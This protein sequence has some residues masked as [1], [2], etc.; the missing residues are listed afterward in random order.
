MIISNIRRKDKL[1]ID[2]DVNAWEKFIKE[3]KFINS[4][5]SYFTSEF[6]EKYLFGFNQYINGNWEIARNKLKE[7][8][9]LLPFEDEPIKNLL[10]FMEEFEESGAIWRGYREE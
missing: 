4:I 6:Y 1:K 5:N 3:D 10:S 9:S 8:S 7:A 2:A